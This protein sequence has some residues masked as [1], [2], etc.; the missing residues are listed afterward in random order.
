MLIADISIRKPVMTVM[1]IGGLMLLGYISI[2]RIGVDLFPKV[3]FPYIGVQTVL[4]GAAPGTIETEVTNPMEEELNSIAGLKNLSSV[5][6]DSVSM[7]MADFNLDADPDVKAQEVRNKVDLAISRL[8][9]DAEPP[10]VQ[11][12]DPNSAPIL[13]VMISGNMEVRELTEYADKVVKERLQRISGV[14]GIQL[15]GG[16]EREMRIWLDAYKLRSYGVTV[17][18]VFNAIRLEHAEIPGGR[19]DTRGGHSEFMVKT[20]GELLNINEFEK[21][22]FVRTRRVQDTGSFQ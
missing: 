17:Q 1:V 4:E 7:V 6:T 21:N 14:G 18:D 15:L 2:D 12:M 10:I 9:A 8:P 16:R 20:K 11:K 19:L 3:E 5:S 22:F 13:T